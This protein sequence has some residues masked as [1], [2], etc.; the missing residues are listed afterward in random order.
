MRYASA[1]AFRTALE[2]RLLTLT[3]QTGVPLLRLRKLVVF[4]RLLVR[5]MVVAPDRW[6][7]KGAVALHFRVG[8]RFRTTR[9]LD[10]GRH[11]D[12]QAATVD[13][14]LAQSVQ[15]GDYFTFAIHRT[16]K[17]DT[18]LEAAAVRYHVIAEVDGRPFEHITVDVGF[19]DPPALGFEVLRGPDLLSFAD[20]PPAEVPALP[21]ELHIAEKVH[22]YTR[23]YAGRRTSSRVKDLVDLAAMA[24]LFP[25]EAGRLGSALQ[26]TFGTRDTHSLP[27]TLPPPPSHWSAAYRRMATEL[28][29]DPELYVG[30]GQ[31]RAFLGPILAKTLPDAGR[32]DP[33]RRIWS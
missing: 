11:D 22:A 33:T 4:D 30:Y 1:G 5:L 18:L 16:G 13:F 12:E 20:I 8:P 29:L 15:L 3:E 31:V 24:S 9:D 19:G 21:L 27:R 2:R 17:L 10:L 25:F 14:G 6:I 23:A 32:W 26:A 7:L 28:G